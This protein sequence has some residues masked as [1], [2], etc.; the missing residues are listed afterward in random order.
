ME[1]NKVSNK[2]CIK[3]NI[4]IGV[5]TKVCKLCGEAQPMKRKLQ[6]KIKKYDEACAS[7]PMENGN[8]NNLFDETNLLV[9]QKVVW[10]L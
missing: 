7:A 10:I 4:A 8:L 5:A 2:K 9:R 1:S 3:C 6:K